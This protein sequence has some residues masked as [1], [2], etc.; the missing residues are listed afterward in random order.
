MFIANISHHYMFRVFYLFS[1]FLINDTDL[2]SFGMW[3]PLKDILGPAWQNNKHGI[4]PCP[5]LDVWVPKKIGFPELIKVEHSEVKGGFSIA[6]FCYALQLLPFKVQ[7]VFKPFINDKGESNGTYDQLVQ[8]IE[9]KTCQAVAGDVTVR[10][11]RAEL[12]DFTIPYLSS[13]VYMLVQGSHEWNQT[14]WTFLRP[15]TWRL[16]IT[17]VGT[18]IFIGAAVAILEY[19]VGNPKFTAPYFQTLRMVIWF[20]I[21]TFF[22]NEGTYLS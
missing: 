8:H 19:R 2:G 7:P 16:W 17:I 15:F 12:V 6:I 22:F 9:G 3:L 14:L 20:P 1:F 11:S 13:E 10:A 5:E 18:C 21:S 4:S